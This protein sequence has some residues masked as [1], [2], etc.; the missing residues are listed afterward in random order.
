MTSD[1]PARFRPLRPPT[2]A[3]R[4]ALLLAGPLLWVAALVIV[5]IVADETN[6]IWIGLVIAGG[7]FL[8]GAVFLLLERAHRLKEERG[9]APRR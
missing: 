6:L 4:V 1:T 9:P 7:S 3:G 5:A 8:L 2:W